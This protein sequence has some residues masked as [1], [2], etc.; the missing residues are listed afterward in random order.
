MYVPNVNKNTHS[1]VIHF[2]LV[3]IKMR[4]WKCWLAKFNYKQQIIT[5]SSIKLDN[6]AIFMN[7]QVFKIFK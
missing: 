7:M 3:L 6:D 5:F 1:H 2:S 4:Q